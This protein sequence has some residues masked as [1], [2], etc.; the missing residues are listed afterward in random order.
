MAR[1]YSDIQL[2][3][4]LHCTQRELETEFDADFI[5]NL[6]LIMRREAI[7]SNKQRKQ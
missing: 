6:M 2:C 1:Q 5:E 7:Y 3:R 4:E